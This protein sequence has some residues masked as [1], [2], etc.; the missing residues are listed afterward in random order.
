LVHLLGVMIDNLVGAMAGDGL[1]LT[2]G[3]ASFQ[4]VDGCVLTKAVQ[5]VFVVVTT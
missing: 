2:I 5:G 4:K 3:A 1:S